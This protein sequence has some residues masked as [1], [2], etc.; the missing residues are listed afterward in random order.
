MWPAGISGHSITHLIS[1]SQY[2]LALHNLQNDWSFTQALELFYSVIN[3]RFGPFTFFNALF[4]FFFGVGIWQ[5]ILPQLTLGVIGTGLAFL[6]GRQIGGLVPAVFLGLSFATSPWHLAFSRYADAEHIL[7]VTQ[8]LLW[9]YSAMLALRKQTLTWMF[10]L[11]ATTGTCWYVYAASMFQ[12]LA[13]A[14]F[15]LILLALKAVPGRTLAKFCLSLVLGFTLTSAA[16][17]LV[18]MEQTGSLAAISRQDHHVDESLLIREGFPAWLRSL[19]TELVVQ[20]HD[21]WFYRPNGG[22]GVLELVLPLISGIIVT[23]RARRREFDL[24][25]LFIISSLA[26]AFLPALLAPSTPFRRLMF[27]AAN[28]QFMSCIAVAFFA[29]YWA[30]VDRMRRIMLAGGACLLVLCL[31]REA[32]TYFTNVEQPEADGHAFQ[33]RAAQMAQHASAQ[34]KL[35]L[36]V[37]E[38]YQKDQIAALISL[39]LGILPKI[40]NLQD[41]GIFVEV[42]SPF[43]PGFGSTLGANNVAKVIARMDC[44]NFNRAESSGFIGAAAA[45]MDRYGKP[46]LYY[47]ERIE[48]PAVIS[49]NANHG[50]GKTAMIGSPK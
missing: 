23:L 32:L 6:A 34:N 14:L 37:T 9:M 18:R 26:C 43:S 41:L 5:S 25:H 44:P 50:L 28:L 47:W 8:Y 42:A 36:C 7:G 46:L 15:F 48:N 2:N 4:F 30:H 35:L 27:V 10:V 1:A 45:V 16:H 49:Q 19:S 22:L 33:L 31:S 13:I 24:T 12:P 11:G 3:E 29:S 40:Q 38:A 20:T 21:E 17:V 39:S